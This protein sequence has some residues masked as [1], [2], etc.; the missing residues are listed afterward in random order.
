MSGIH[1]HSLS[2]AFSTQ[3]RQRSWWFL[4]PANPAAIPT[5][6]HPRRRR[7]ANARKAALAL[8][9]LTSAFLACRCFGSSC[10]AQR[11]F[12]P[13]RSCLPDSEDECR[14]AG[15]GGGRIRFCSWRRQLHQARSPRSRLQASGEF[16]A[17]ARAR[18][19]TKQWQQELKR[20][21]EWSLLPC[22]HPPSSSAGKQHEPPSRL[23]RPCSH[24]AWPRRKEGRRRG[25]CLLS[26]LQK[27]SR[28]L[29]EEKSHLNYS[30]SR[31]QSQS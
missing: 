4:S 13:T 6:H 31:K 24:A 30:K 5:R 1:T 3:R 26:H 9:L 22:P 29:K 2:G 27:Q 8:A 19:R 20:L 25:I 16:S 11:G 7:G 14:A 21:A 28:C 10:R 23:P 17:P 18:R 12:L 15:R